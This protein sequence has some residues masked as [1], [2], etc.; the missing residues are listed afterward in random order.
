MCSVILTTMRY[1]ELGICL[2]LFV[3]SSTTGINM[4]NKINS[5]NFQ[6]IHLIRKLFKTYI[7]I[8]L[9]EE[10][11]SYSEASFK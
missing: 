2:S 7:T 9:F 8:K 4:R 1:I 5:F 6:H 11:N 3:I 10:D